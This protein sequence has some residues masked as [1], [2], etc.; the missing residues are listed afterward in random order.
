MTATFERI[1]LA[2]SVG[3]ALAALGGGYYMARCSGD[4]HWMNRAGAAV[5]AAEGVIV[6]VEFIRRSRLQKIFYNAM[7][8]ARKE[9]DVR[10]G[11][12]TQKR[13]KVLNTLEHEIERA[14][15][16]VLVVAILLA[17]VGE[18]LHGFGDILFEH[19]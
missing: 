8:N 14:E 9:Q 13:A 1:I 18:L 3:C 10:G 2:G 11:G 16:H 19:L 4:P 6:V 7:L 5:V 12:D 15:L 17:M